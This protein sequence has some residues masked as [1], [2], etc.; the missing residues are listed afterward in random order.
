[1]GWCKIILKEKWIGGLNIPALVQKLPHFDFSCT[2]A[3]F[4]LSVCTI[5]L[6]RQTCLI[7]RSPDPN[8][9]SSMHSWCNS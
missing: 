3:G 4:Y 6:I 5:S 7:S 8:S 2:I 9:A 1:V